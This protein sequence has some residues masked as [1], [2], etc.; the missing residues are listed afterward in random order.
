MAK[1]P[2]LQIVPVSRESDGDVM[3]TVARVTLVSGDWPS[4]SALVRRV[5]PMAAFGY[6]SPVDDRTREVE[7][8]F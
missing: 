2:T 4:D 5:D 1:A 8:V 7:A 3:R 6:V